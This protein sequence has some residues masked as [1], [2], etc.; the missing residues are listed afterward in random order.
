[1]AAAVVAK[2]SFF[3]V[4]LS[5][6]LASTAPSLRSESGGMRLNPV[7]DGHAL[8]LVVGHGT[9]KRFA[10]G[11]A[12]CGKV[13]PVEGEEALCDYPSQVFVAIGQRVIV[14]DGDEQS[15]GRVREAK[16]DLLAEHRQWCDESRQKK[17]PVANVKPT[18]TMR[19]ST[20]AGSRY[21]VT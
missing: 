5:S 1:M 2:A 7:H 20:S 17:V 16:V 8:N 18:N 13:I 6:G 3:N 14:V 15:G 10:V 4:L 9:P 21:S 11:R 12:A 19:S